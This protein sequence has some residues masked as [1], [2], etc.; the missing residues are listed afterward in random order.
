MIDKQT[1]NKAMAKTSIYDLN[2]HLFLALERV[3]DDLQD[4]G[5]TKKTEEELLSDINRAKAVSEIG[6]II[7]D[8]ANTML[9]VAELHYDA[10]GKN[11]VLPDMFTKKETPNLTE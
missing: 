11:F 4:D 5:E 6:K 10:T 1:E 3:N 2:E 9:R 8:G 7:I